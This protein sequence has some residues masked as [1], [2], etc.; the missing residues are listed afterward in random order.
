MKLF[1]DLAFS[2]SRRFLHSN[3]AQFFLTVAFEN[4]AD[5]LK[6]YNFDLNFNVKGT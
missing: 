6:G 5:I 2:I 1:L 3:I 4:V